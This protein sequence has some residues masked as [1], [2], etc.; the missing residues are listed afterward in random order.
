MPSNYPVRVRD[1]IAPDV[2][3]D[4]RYCEANSQ[5]YLCPV[6]GCWWNDEASHA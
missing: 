4:H 3:H 6:P 5:P 2:D 1:I